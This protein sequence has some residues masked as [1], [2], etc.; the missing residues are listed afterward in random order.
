MC[1]DITAV[2]KVVD[3]ELDNEDQEYI[4]IFNRTKSGRRQCNKAVKKLNN[5]PKE[6]KKLNVNA[7]VHKWNCTDSEKFLSSTLNLEGL[8]WVR[9]GSI[10]MF[11]V[12]VTR[13]G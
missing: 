8:K 1:D 12:F 13:A 4:V 9:K 3:L 10:K 7:K 6:L 5:L 11:S 2:E